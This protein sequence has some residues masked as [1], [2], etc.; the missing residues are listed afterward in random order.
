MSKRPVLSATGDFLG[1]RI[2]GYHPAAG[3]RSDV[4]AAMLIEREVPCGEG[5]APVVEGVTEGSTPLTP[6]GQIT[7]ICVVRATFRPMHLRFRIG[8]VDLTHH[9]G[10]AI[11]A[12]P[13]NRVHVFAK[14]V[15]LQGV[16][17]APPQIV[18]MIQNP[19]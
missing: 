4:W 2:D 14:L 6:I 1:L 15:V 17:N 16:Q 5:A 12:V 19:D 18:V 11:V 9:V 3:K 10:P 13:G 8:V 7:G